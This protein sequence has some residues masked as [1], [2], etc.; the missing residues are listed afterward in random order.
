MKSKLLW[1]NKN[2]EEAFKVIADI[3]FETITEVRKQDYLNLK[4]KYFETFKDFNKAYDCFS[5]SNLLAKNLM[6]I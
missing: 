2:K 1:R 3:D 5:K 4:A 6:I